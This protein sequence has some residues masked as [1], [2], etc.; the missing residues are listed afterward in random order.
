MCTLKYFPSQIED[1][2]EW[3]QGNFVYLFINSITLF[4]D[5]INNSIEDYL[6]KLN[7]KANSDF[8]DIVKKYNH[9]KVKPEFMTYTKLWNE[10]EQ[11]IKDANE[12]LHQ[13]L[14]HR[15]M[16]HTQV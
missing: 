15:Y 11:Q 9:I 7:E 3:S 5:F 6:K 2:I 16:R 10:I 14:Y 4:K 13:Y 8:I 1:C 12:D